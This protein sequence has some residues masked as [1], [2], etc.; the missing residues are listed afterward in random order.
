[1]SNSFLCSD[2]EEFEKMKLSARTVCEALAKLTN[3][4][5]IKSL[6]LNTVNK[7]VLTVAGSGQ[8]L[9]KDDSERASLPLKM[10]ELDLEPRGDFLP[11]QY[12]VGDQTY[13]STMMT[14]PGAVNELVLSLSQEK[15]DGP[16][17]V[18][19]KINQ[20]TDKG[21]SYELLITAY[22][23][24]DIRIEA[25]LAEWEIG[26]SLSIDTE[27]YPDDEVEEEYNPNLP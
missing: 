23:M 6:S 5:T 14:F 2:T 9:V 12:T 20:S 21:K 16:R 24:Q 17:T 25:S 8:G 11:V 13:N 18:T 15:Q 3:K 22:S 26:E 7:G 27:E 1:M 4:V 19:V 10:D